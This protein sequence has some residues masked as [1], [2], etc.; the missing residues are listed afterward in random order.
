[1]NESDKLGLTQLLGFCR[2]DGGSDLHSCFFAR[3][4]ERVM[5]SGDAFKLDVNSHPIFNS[6]ALSS[7][8]FV[9]V[10]SVNCLQMVLHQLAM[11]SW[12]EQRV[13]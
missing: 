11:T 5:I 10:A 1:M 6:G 4:V 8:S 12:M 13:S 2:V 7:C 9:I 3:Y